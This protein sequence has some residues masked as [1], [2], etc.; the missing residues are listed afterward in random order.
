MGLTQLGRS[1]SWSAQACRQ[2][3]TT[4]SWLLYCISAESV[5]CH[6]TAHAAATISPSIQLASLPGIKSFVWA[7]RAWH[8]D[9]ASCCRLLTGCVR[10]LTIGRQSVVR[11]V[12]PAWSPAPTLTVWC[13]SPC[14]ATGWSTCHLLLT[15][16]PHPLACPMKVCVFL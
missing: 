10:Q 15:S 2:A 14:L 11:T 8:N 5:A 9:L 1:G 6:A 16:L 4:E 13:A 7:S 3:A 12:G